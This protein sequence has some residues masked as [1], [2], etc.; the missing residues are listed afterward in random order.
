MPI[1]KETIKHIKTIAFNFLWNGS[2][3]G[4]VKRSAMIADIDKGG[5]KFPDLDTIVKTQHICWIKRFFFS[6]PHPWKEI[7]TWQLNKING[8]KVLQHT[9]LDNRFI[10]SSTVLPFYKN[11][12]RSWSQWIE[13]GID[14]SNVLNQQLNLNVHIKRPNQQ[15]IHYPRLQKKGIIVI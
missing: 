1:P 13:E 6:P 9:A 4:K 12:I 11:V 2:E 15:T 7:F 10:E 14:E 5:I 3:R 8:I